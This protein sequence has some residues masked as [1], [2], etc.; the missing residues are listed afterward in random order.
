MSQMI[1]CD[2]CGAEV[3]S[4]S[5][6]GVTPTFLTEEEVKEREGWTHVSINISRKYREPEAPVS[7]HFSGPLGEGQITTKP[8][9]PSPAMLVAL[10]SSLDLC[11][12]CSEKFLAALGEEPRKKI[13]TEP[14]LPPWARS[15]PV[16]PLRVVKPGPPGPPE[17]AQP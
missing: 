11:P 17:S 3:R 5:P 2:G 15:A 14:T 13:T 4:L 16:V 9:A 1:Q 10:A 6:H 8:A 12:A 7:H